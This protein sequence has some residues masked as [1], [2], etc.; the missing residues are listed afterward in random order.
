LVVLYWDNWQF[1]QEV[2]GSDDRGDMASCDFI[3]FVHHM[4]F[5]CTCCCLQS[6]KFES[7]VSDLTWL[8]V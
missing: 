5:C 4:C 1:G 6:A 2:K 8:V 3:T 7:Q